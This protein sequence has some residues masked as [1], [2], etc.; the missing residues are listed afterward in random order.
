MSDKRASLVAQLVK[1]RPTMWGDTLGWEDPLK[2][3]LL[4]TPVFWPEEFLGLYSPWS[5][6]ETDTTERLSLHSVFH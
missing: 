3:K 2:K 6:K 1:N 5:H 4:P